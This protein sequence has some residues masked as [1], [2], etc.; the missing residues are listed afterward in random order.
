M[1]FLQHSDFEKYPGSPLPSR[2]KILGGRLVARR[3][4]KRER[5]AYDDWDT[6]EANL[7]AKG[8]ASVEEAIEKEPELVPALL[9]FALRAL[10]WANRNLKKYGNKPV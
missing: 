9:P 6:I 1:F 5:E 7:K 3:N 10:G 8:Y 4:L 2:G